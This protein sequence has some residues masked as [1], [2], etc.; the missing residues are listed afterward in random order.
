MIR[1]A[2]R[3]SSRPR[4]EC[5]VHLALASSGD[6]SRGTGARPTQAARRAATL[7]EGGVAGRP[8]EASP[9]KGR[10]LTRHAPAPLDFASS[11]PQAVASDPL[12]RDPEPLR[13]PTTTVEVRA[14]TRRVF[15]V[16]GGRPMPGGRP[17]D[18]GKPLGPEWQD[19]L[20]PRSPSG[21]KSLI[22]TVAA[23]SLLG[24][25]LAVESPAEAAAF[26]SP[27]AGTVA[28]D[29]RPVVLDFTASWC[30]PC[31]TMAPIVRDL[32]ARGLPIRAVDI[33]ERPELAERYEVTGV[34]AFVVVA[35]DGREL[36]RLS[37]SCPPEDLI[38]L[39]KAG[40]ARYEQ[41]VADSRVTL[42]GQSPEIAAAPEIADDEPE[43]E[44]D[45]R[46]SQPWE[47]VVR[48]K[49]ID[50]NLIGFGSGTIIHSTD[51]EALILTCAHIFHIDRLGRRQA[52]PAKFPLRVVVDLFDGTLRE[53]NTKNRTPFLL[54]TLTDVPAQV[55]DYNFA[56][57]VGLIRIKTGRRLPYAPVVPPGWTPELGMKMITLGCAQGNNASAWG[58]RV[59]NPRV[60]SIIN[61]GRYRGTECAFGPIEGRSGGG[62]FT[63]DGALAGVCDF[64]DTSNNDRGLYAAPATIH[65]MLERNRPRL[66]ATGLEICYAGND[67]GRRDLTLIAANSGRR[68]PRPIARARLEPSR[69]RFVRPDRCPCPVSRRIREAADPFDRAPRRQYPRVRPPRHPRRPAPRGPGPHRAS[70]PLAAGQPGDGPRSQ[71]PGALA[72][73]ED[74]RCPPR[75]LPGLSRP[76]RPLRRPRFA[77]RRPLPQRADPSPRARSLPERSRS[78]IPP[79]AQFRPI[80]AARRLR[81]ASVRTLAGRPRP[82]VTATTLRINLQANEF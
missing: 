33:D 18:P 47:T 21:M 70:L 15:R 41:A 61:G 44:G 35:P 43:S 56:G 40:L 45:D 74:A 59:T 8:S 13:A 51:S 30:G 80:L 60:D 31:R 26:V 58:T 5:L 28:A 66:E 82:E 52:T 46:A 48:I 64:R 1:D 65:E 75:P 10:D 42:R 25:V 39:Y 50:K 14:A 38:R 19:G 62:L 81:L 77:P 12:G 16:Q 72:R 73:L 69:R 63:L 55:I 4:P 3:R 32:E 2:R 17:D 37:G 36:G 49:V 67:A 27:D 24:L 79:R 6:V 78:R 29:E 53:S 68:T 9:G 54:P 23:V 7:Q 76:G 57:D 20:E 34:P 22:K 71:A 11:R